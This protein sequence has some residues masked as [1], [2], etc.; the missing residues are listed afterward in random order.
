[1]L[2]RLSFPVTTVAP[3]VGVALSHLLDTSNLWKAQALM[4]MMWN[5]EAIK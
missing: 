3:V 4:P 5:L 2:L 1:M